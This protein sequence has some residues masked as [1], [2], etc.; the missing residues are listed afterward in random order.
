MEYTSTGWPAE[1]AEADVFPPATAAPPA[2]S[3]TPSGSARMTLGISSSTPVY[4]CEGQK[5]PQ[6]RD[7]FFPYNP[8]TPPTPPPVPPRKARFR[9]ISAPFGSVSAPFGSVWLRFGSVLGPFRDRFG[10]VSGCW[11]GWGWGRRE[12]FCKGKEYH[13]RRARNARKFKATKKERKSDS[14]GQPGSNEKV[15]RK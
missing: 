13:Y 5:V 6:T 2:E 7:F 3:A 4:T 12:G 15:T 8:P 9:F 1:Y 11:M 14:G 10:S